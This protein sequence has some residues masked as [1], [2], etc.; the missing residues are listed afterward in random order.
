MR[1]GRPSRTAARVAAHR[2]RF[3]RVPAPFGDPGSDEL[4]ASD[5]AEGESSDL[6]SP[7]ARYLR[8]RTAFID[9]TVCATLASGTRQ[10]VAV[11]SGYDG[12]ALRYAKPGVR[13]FELDHPD[14][15]RDK[16]SRLQRLGIQTRDVAYAETD[17]AKRTLTAALLRTGFDPTVPSL[18]LCEGVAAYL[19]IEQLEALLT[20][21]RGL[22]AAGSLLALTLSAALH[23]AAQQAARDRLQAAVK[24]VGEPIANSLTAQAAEPLLAATGWATAPGSEPA[25]HSG[26]VLAIPGPR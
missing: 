9:A 24:A 19:S 18:L 1:D 22:A 25:R 13:W 16:R 23:T 26:F 14:T 8:G 5:V 7:M 12:R 6:D 17:L 4:L 11:G 2:L 10:V 21:L 15:S 3:D 20:D